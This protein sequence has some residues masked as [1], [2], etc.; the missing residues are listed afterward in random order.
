M[1]CD[2]KHMSITDS[3]LRAI[4][5]ITI[6]GIDVAVWWLDMTIDTMHEWCD[7]R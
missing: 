4:C 2:G 6:G 5:G 1:T 7:V 3:E